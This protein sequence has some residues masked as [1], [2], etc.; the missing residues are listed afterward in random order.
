MHVRLEDPRQ[1]DIVALIQAL[2]A[3]QMPLYPI[4]SHHGIDIEALSRPEVR[5]AVLRDAR[6][7]AVGCGA[8]VLNGGNAELKRMYI[9]PQWR[10]Q[11]LGRRL[12][13][14]LEQQARDAGATQC[15]LETGVRQPEAIALYRRC[16][17][18]EIPPFAPYLADPLSLFMSKRL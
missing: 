3:Y 10:G 8:I 15:R 1:H 11:G 16:G 2:D 4:E 12:L 13:D 5:F 9:A 18:V 7:C 14:F 6:Q 17:Y